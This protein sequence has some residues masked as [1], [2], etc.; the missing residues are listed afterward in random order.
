M[1]IRMDFVSNSSSSSFVLWGAEITRQELVDAWKKQNEDTPADE[2][3]LEICE[4]YDNMIDSNFNR[5]VFDYDSNN[6]Y[7][8]CSPSKMNDN[9]TLGEFKQKIVDS[10]KNIGIEKTV[11]QIRLFTG[12]IFDGEGIE[13]GV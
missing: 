6:A 9:E 11:D 1:K 8:G 13:F 5:A 3:D 12:T 10:L 2:D 7:A 4:I